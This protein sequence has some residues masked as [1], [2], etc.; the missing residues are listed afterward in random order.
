MD[1]SGPTNCPS[2][3]NTTLEP[4]Y[5]HS[6]FGMDYH[7]STK[8]NTEDVYTKNDTQLIELEVEFMEADENDET[9]ATFYLIGV[10]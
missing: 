7:L 5:V 6:G 4:A 3:Y 10:E 9:S 8:A 2:L 1:K